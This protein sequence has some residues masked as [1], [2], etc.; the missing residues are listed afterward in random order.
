VFSHA[1]NRYQ[2]RLMPLAPLA[3]MIVLVGR[4][5]VC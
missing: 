4:R 3:M 1:S 2:S 5:R